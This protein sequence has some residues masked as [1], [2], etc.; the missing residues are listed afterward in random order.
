[1]SRVDGE[2]WVEDPVLYDL[3]TVARSIILRRSDWSVGLLVGTQTSSDWWSSS[4]QRQVP[5]AWHEFSA[6][7]CQAI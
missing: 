5:M 6:A 3:G 1:M 4:S 2:T 7:G